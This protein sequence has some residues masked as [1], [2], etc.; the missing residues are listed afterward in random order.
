[1]RESRTYGS[2]RGWCREALVY[3]THAENL[4]RNKAV[5]GGSSEPPFAPPNGTIVMI[6]SFSLS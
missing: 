1:M 3:S 2:V 6:V 4:I 5:R